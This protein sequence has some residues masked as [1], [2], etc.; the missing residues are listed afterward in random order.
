MEADEWHVEAAS[1]YLER[2]VTHGCDGAQHAAASVI[3]VLSAGEAAVG[4]TVQ[5]HA[6][7]R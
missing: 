1:G 3:A 2:G 7:A 5:V 4:N 6:A